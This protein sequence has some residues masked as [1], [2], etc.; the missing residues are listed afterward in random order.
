V[1]KESPSS[2][3]ARLRAWLEG[4]IEGIGNSEPSQEADDLRR[5]LWEVIDGLDALDGGERPAIFTPTKKSSWY[6]KGAKGATIPKLKM[7]A[8]SYVALLRKM[9]DA[10]AQT[11]DKNY[12][13]EKALNLVADAYGYKQEG[14]GVL[15]KWEQ[16]FQQTCPDELA[17][18]KWVM[19]CLYHYQRHAGWPNGTAALLENIKRAG[20]KF[21]D[22]Q[23]A[24]KESR[25]VKNKK[26]QGKKVAPVLTE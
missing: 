22:I 23:K 16:K 13:A 14:G 11:K 20:K 15:K 17:E 2:S 12:K 24:A 8:L 1:T 26:S 9:D 3:R 7:E 25:Q 21:Q 18:A 19:R 6:G 10:N 5:L 4:E